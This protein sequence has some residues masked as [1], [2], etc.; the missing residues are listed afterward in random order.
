[1]MLPSGNVIAMRNSDTL[2]FTTDDP[3]TRKWDNAPESE[4]VYSTSFTNCLVLNFMCEW[5]DWLRLPYLA[6]VIHNSCLG[7]ACWL[8]ASFHCL[9][10]VLASTLLF[11]LGSYLLGYGYCWW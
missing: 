3:S 10:L 2:T 7:F 6:I 1:M 5:R 11:H 4:S 9:C 8:L